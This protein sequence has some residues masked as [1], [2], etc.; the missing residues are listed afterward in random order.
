[1]SPALDVHPPV[2]HLESSD[3]TA[4]VA[5]DSHDF[6]SRIAAAMS[7]PARQIDKLS[8][9][10]PRYINNPVMTYKLSYD[11][12]TRSSNGSRSWAPRC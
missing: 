11:L 2:F 5:M 3:D 6:L 1:M 7:F 4:E 12:A 10:S 8:I 9:K